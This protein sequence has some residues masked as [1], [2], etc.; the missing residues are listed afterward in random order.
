MYLTALY[1]PNYYLFQY[2]LWEYNF[3]LRLYFQ[4]RNQGVNQGINI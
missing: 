4:E 3:Y 1:Y 2:F